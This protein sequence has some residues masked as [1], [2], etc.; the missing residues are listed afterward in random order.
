MNLFSYDEIP[1]GFAYEFTVDVGDEKQ[2]HEMELKF[3]KP[4]KEEC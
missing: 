2:I 3:L 4:V 1:V